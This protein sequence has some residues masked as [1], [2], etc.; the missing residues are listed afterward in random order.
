MQIF[1][2]D[3]SDNAVVAANLEA[4]RKEHQEAEEQLTTE[5]QAPTNQ[6]EVASDSDKTVV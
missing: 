3:N 2:Q 4:D 1:N 6:A 5:D